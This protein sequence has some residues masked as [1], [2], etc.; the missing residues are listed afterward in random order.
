MSKYVSG[1]PSMKEIKNADGEVNK[2]SKKA[3]TNKKSR[4]K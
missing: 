1:T 4:S 2:V 3:K